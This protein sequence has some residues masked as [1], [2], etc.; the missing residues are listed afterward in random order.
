[1]A[2]PQDRLDADAKLSTIF[3]LKVGKHPNN[4]LRLT[5]DVLPEYHAGV[6]EVLG[7]H[8]RV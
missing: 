7:V 2:S 5:L 3:S 4:V 6:A 8:G 1:M